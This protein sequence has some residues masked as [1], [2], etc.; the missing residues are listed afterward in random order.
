MSDTRSQQPLRRDTVRLRAAAERQLRVAI[1]A[2]GRFHVLDLA[3]QLDRLGFDVRFYSY[4][5]RRRA[6]RFGLPRRCHV[7][8]LPLV[9]PIVAW[10]R[11]KPDLMP[12]LQERAMFRALN[13]AVIARLLPCDVF[14]CMSGIYLEA[15]RHA[16]KRFGARIFIERGSRHILSQREILAEIAGAIGPSDLA[17]GRELAGYALADRIVVPS[18]HVAESFARDPDAAAKLFVDPYGVDLDQFPP[19]SA[20]APDPTVLFVGAWSYRKGVDVLASAVLQ[21]PGVHLLH[22]GGFGDA[23]FPDHPRI[24]HHDPVEQFELSRFYGKAH[25]FVMPSREE[26]MALV[27]AQAL[28]SGLPLVCTERSG[29]ADLAHSPAV[30]RRI[31]VVAAGD[32]TALEEGIKAALADSS[33]AECSGPL[34]A[35]DRDLLSWQAYG[36]RY[37]A[38]LRRTM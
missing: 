9:A 30:A 11:L 20:A 16:K 6:E 21:M 12:A 26:G 13:A 14:I 22:V 15:A 23:P 27:Q 28:A 18:A 38:E 5:P 4:V 7:G 34:V 2:A 32:L 17:V 33:V 1:A 25:V 8:L 37:A 35:E 36:E 31:R 3:R 19:R 10:Q 29:G 24:H